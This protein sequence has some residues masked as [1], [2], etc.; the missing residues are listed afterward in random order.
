MKHGSTGMIRP[1]R[2]RPVL[3]SVTLRNLAIMD[4]VTVEFDEGLNVITGPTGSGKSLLIQGLRLTLGE[5]ADFGMIADGEDQ[6]TVSSFFTVDGDRERLP[7]YVTEP[8]VHFRRLL[9]D[10][11]KSKA[12][13]NDERVRLD[14]LRTIRPSLID[15]HGQ[16]ENQAVFE[17]EFPRRV[18]DRFGDY[19]ETL[20]EY[21]EEYEGF[22]E[23][24]DELDR[25]TDSDG[26]Q[27]QRVEFLEYQLSELGEFEPGEDEWEAIEQ[28]RRRLEQGEE[29]NEKLQR[30]IG[31]L[32]S[33][34]S[35]QHQLRDVR[36]A[37]EQLAEFDDS[38]SDWESELQD[39]VAG[40]EEC[41][42]QLRRTREE[43][44]YSEA[45]YEDL[46]DRR[47]RWMELAR[48]HDVPPEQ[49]HDRYQ[50]LTEELEQLKNRDERI[51]TLREEVEEIRPRLESKGESLSEERRDAADRLEQ[52]IAERLNAL[53]LEESEFDV[54]VETDE[55]GPHGLDRVRWLFASHHTQE[56]GP[57]S[58]R[59]S[60]GEISRVLLSVKSALAG[61]DTTPT[62]VFDEID[63][64]IS[65][66]EADSVGAVLSR[67]SE[68][69]Q[70]IC[71]THLP[72]VA[73]HADHHVVIE[74]EDTAD[75]VS[76]EARPV[77]GDE[78]LDEL[79]RLLSGDRDSDVSRDQARELLEVTE[80]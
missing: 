72:L 18:L 66:K 74:R 5:R 54:R 51:E 60:G 43:F 46:M 61:A 33:D 2:N 36:D 16:H 75:T 57:L 30:A 56:L 25:L 4:D 47:G 34:E 59:V 20:E 1:G 67:L 65:G 64:G 42:R 29:L 10:S 68:F 63:T 28:K 15:F 69:H 19:D 53:N 14:S 3:E 7:E 79:S 13:L 37:V 52:A 80:E 27:Q 77:A 6:A 50:S 23:K 40:L 78:R 26:N 62:L 41:R 17:T 9:K 76:V 71:I 24:K 58:D 21:R 22:R 8:E 44:D 70:V 49:L 39:Y 48:K 11:R 32:D 38:L 45:E 31:I 55:P 73:S 35:P 12:F